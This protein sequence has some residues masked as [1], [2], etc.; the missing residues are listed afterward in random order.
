ME[1]DDSSM[2]K[3]VQRGLQGQRRPEDRDDS[4][5]EG[6]SLPDLVERVVLHDGSSS[7]GSLGSINLPDLMDPSSDD[8]SD[9]RSSEGPLPPVPRLVRRADESSSEGS[10]VPV[11]FSVDSSSGESYASLPPALFPAVMSIPAVILIRENIIVETVM[12]E[13][14]SNMCDTGP[15][16]LPGDHPEL[17]GLPGAMW[18]EPVEMPSAARIRGGGLDDINMSEPVEA[19]VST[20]SIMPFHSVGRRVVES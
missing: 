19:S 11:A 3:L 18:L 2:P 15:H 6:S 12:E 5:S 20:V 13:G 1:E 8:E 14:L 4:S 9:D 10:S 16:H 17:C 7:E